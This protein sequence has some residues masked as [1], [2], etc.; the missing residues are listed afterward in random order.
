M[1][2]MGSNEQCSFEIPDVD[3]REHEPGVFTA[4]AEAFMTIMK[5]AMRADEKLT[6]TL[7]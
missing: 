2:V 5:D 1:S 3:C 6:M 4:D 7:A